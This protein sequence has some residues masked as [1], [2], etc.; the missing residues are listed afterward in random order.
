V[1]P[2]TGRIELRGSVS[3]FREKLEAERIVEGAVREAVVNLLEVRPRRPEGDRAIGQAVRAGLRATTGVAGDTVTVDVHGGRALLRGT[4]GSRE[5]RRAAA[6]AA[7][8]VAGVQ[9]IVNLLKIDARERAL[10]RHA[11]EEIRRHLDT[12]EGLRECCLR[13]AVAGG[14]AELS[15]YARSRRQRRRAAR[16]AREYPVLRVRNEIAVTG[17]AAER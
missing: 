3:S 13:V 10:D 15:G 4:V 12:D 9:R 17:R 5:E 11:A 6:D 2:R 16:V 1:R 8:A 7:L 14:T